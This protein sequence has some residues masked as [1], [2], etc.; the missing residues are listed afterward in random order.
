MEAEALAGAGSRA[1]GLQPRATGAAAL[2]A[3]CSGDQEV[4]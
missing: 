4:S 1:E 2:R 3:G